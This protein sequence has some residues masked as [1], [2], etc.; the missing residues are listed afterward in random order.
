MGGKYPPFV[1]KIKIMKKILMIIIFVVAINNQLVFSQN[2]LQGEIIY[3][4]TYNITKLENT[5]ILQFNNQLSRYQFID[6]IKSDR[7]WEDRKKR[8][9]DEARKKGEIH[10]VIP[11]VREP[12]E[13]DIYNF[14][15]KGK[16]N[17]LYLKGKK[18][19]PFDDTNFPKDSLVL[20]EEDNNRIE[21]KIMNKF[22][23]ILNYNCQYA[24][25]EFRGRKYDVWFA[26]DLPL[27]IGPWKLNGLP[28]IILEALD[29]DKVYDFKAIKINLQLV[30]I[31]D[32]NYKNLYK[33]ISLKEKIMV[34]CVYTKKVAEIIS[35]KMLANAGPTA[36]IINE[37]DRMNYSGFLYKNIVRENDFEK[38]DGMKD[39]IKICPLYMAKL[40]H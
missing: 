13:K 40:K 36:R 7:K 12:T 37:D 25:G 30:Q 1:N 5:G 32:P 6:D 39:F 19:N 10:N 14:L 27:P 33:Q 38:E 28:G 34:Q 31:E 9:E 18:I 35:K 8:I 11:K 16:I 17:Y 15:D 23:K 20:V 29:E 26:V 21:W 24:V 22:K 3:I 2:T 4:D